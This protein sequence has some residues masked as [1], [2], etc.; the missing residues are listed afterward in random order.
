VPYETT[1]LG[2]PVT[3]EG[4]DLNRTCAGGSNRLTS[5]RAVPQNAGGEAETL[6]LRFR[7]RDRR[8]AAARDYHREVSF[9]ITGRVGDRSVRKPGRSGRI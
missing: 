4:V 1:V 5:A 7:L 3:V 6:G 9:R 2:V 8:E